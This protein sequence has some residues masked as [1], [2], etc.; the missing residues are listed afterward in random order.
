MHLYLSIMLL[1]SRVNSYNYTS[2]AKDCFRWLIYGNLDTL[3][4]THDLEDRVEIPVLVQQKIDQRM[5][6]Q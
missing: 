5:S 4:H 1:F 2:S 6:Y 3:L